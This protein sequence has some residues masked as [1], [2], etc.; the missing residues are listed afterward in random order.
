MAIDIQ[1]PNIFEGKSP[2]LAQGAVRDFFEGKTGS[3]NSVYSQFYT[4]WVEQNPSHQIYNPEEKLLSFSKFVTQRY[5]ELAS[6]L[7]Q[8][9]ED[10]EEKQKMQTQLRQ[11]SLILASENGQD[12]SKLISSDQI[13]GIEKNFKESGQQL[14]ILSPTLSTFE[15]GL[16]AISQRQMALLMVRKLQGED[17]KNTNGAYTVSHVSID[18]NGKATFKLDHPKLDRYEMDLGSK[19]A[20]V[21]VLKDTNENIA[22][23]STALPEEVGRIDEGLDQQIQAAKTGMNQA[24]I[25][26]TAEKEA[27]SANAVN[28]AQAANI[29]AYL[30]GKLSSPRL[31]PAA[32]LKPVEL[33]NPY[34]RPQVSGKTPQQIQNIQAAKARV[35]QQK[36]IQ[37]NI[38]KAQ[39][40][41]QKAR[42]EKIRTN[43][44]K[45][46]RQ[47]EKITQKRNS[48]SVPFIAKMAGGGLALTGGAGLGTY[49][50]IQQV[51]NII[52]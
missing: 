16:K 9:I 40:E 42:D 43:R 41:N 13:E 26:R 12:F 32:Y 15:L 22:Q 18:S 48:S 46:Q 5:Q 45:T 14:Q 25:A 30:K 31:D 3:L 20:P 24:F 21:P 1:N 44:L 7:I 23:V 34:Q 36:E 17:Q 19:A 49:S 38:Q 52:H 2:E 37:E 47:N 29:E 6:S 27:N 11:G 50:L 8:K 51:V 35:R 28:A 10:T 39:L 33:K 4:S